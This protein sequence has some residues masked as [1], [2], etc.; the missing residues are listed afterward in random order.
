VLR[1]FVLLIAFQFVGEAL[2]RLG[3]VPVPGPVIGLAL[4]A[5]AATA[6]PALFAEV[7][8]TADLILRHLSLLFVPAG[9]GVL[10]HLDL[11]RRELLPLAAVL[12]L[13]TV[14]TLLVTALVFALLSRG[15]ADEGS[16]RP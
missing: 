13:S 4:L 2:A 8:G 7:E 14:A 5:V 10:Q 15:H 1:P 6:T 9:V 11:F 12:V 16:P 3:G